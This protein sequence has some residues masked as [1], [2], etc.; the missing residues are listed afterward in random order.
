MNPL[1]LGSFC[2]PGTKAAYLGAMAI[3]G[4]NS[5]LPLPDLLTMLRNQHGRLLFSDLGSISNLEV[6]LTP[7]CICGFFISGE[8]VTE[9]ALILE[10][11]VAINMSKRGRFRF[12]SLPGEMI[13][14]RVSVPVDVVNLSITQ[15][16]DQIAWRQSDFILPAKMVLLSQPNCQ[17]DDAM[18]ASFF[19]RAKEWFEI[20]IDAQQLAVKMGIAMVQAQFY[21]LKLREA[22]AIRIGMPKSA[23]VNRP[24]PILVQSS[25]LKVLTTRRVG[26]R[27]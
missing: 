15:M 9:E 17:F 4:S 24:S 14:Q 13:N 22:G 18:V 16:A 8:C 6:Y 11:L 2:W 20:G 23:Y 10:K 19:V 7:A 27:N 26:G 25:R 3:S 5:E 21:I 1:Q 12:E